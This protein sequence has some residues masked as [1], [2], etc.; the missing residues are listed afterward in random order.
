M[1][2][3]YIMTRMGILTF[4]DGITRYSYTSHKTIWFYLIWFDVLLSDSIYNA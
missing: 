2:D 3:F 4:G 1:N